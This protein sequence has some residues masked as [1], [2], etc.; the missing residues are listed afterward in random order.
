MLG[1]FM[2]ALVDCNNFY[3]S[4][5]RLFQPTLEGK[6]VIVL[7]NND[8]CVVARSN[9]AKALGIL[10]G[11]PLFECKQIVQDNKVHVFSSNFPLY[12]DVSRRVMKTL[13]NSVPNIQIYSI[14]EAFLEVDHWSNRTEQAKA[15]RAQVKQDVGIP[16]S[17][18]IAKTKTLAKLANHYAKK[19]QSETGGVYDLSLLN[20]HEFVQFMQNI[21]VEEIWGIGRQSTQKLFS[22]KV[23]TV[24]D[25]MGK[26]PDWIKALLHEP[27]LSTWN[28]L[29]GMVKYDLEMAPQQQ[30]SI[31]STRSFGRPVTELTELSEAL[32][33]Y[34]ARAAEKLRAKKLLVGEVTIYIRTNHFSKSQLQYNISQHISLLQPTNLTNLLIKEVQDLLTVIYKN[35]YLYKK[36]GVIFHNLVPETDFQTGLFVSQKQTEKGLAMIRALDAIRHKMGD[37]Y[38]HFAAEGIKKEWS[39]RSEM[40]T[41]RY[42]TSWNELKKAS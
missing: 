21:P 23:K 5:E 27:G 33:S 3:T 11:Q 18:G 39:V 38:I 35:G 15:L 2:F 1:L 8:G 13:A 10:M 9:E 7:S 20:G 12:G 16:V 32:S 42:T 26:N 28:E 24:Y 19:H 41:P 29:H 37:Q 14:D 25:F 6:P 17:I 36:A 4:C 22:H 40:R 34:A 30:K 31:M